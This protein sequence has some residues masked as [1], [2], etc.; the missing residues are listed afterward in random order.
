MDGAV[1][2]GKVQNVDIE[3]RQ[4]RVFF[5]DVNIMSGWLKV[6]Q[7]PPFIPAINVEQ[8]TEKEL[9]GSGDAAFAEHSHAV[10]IKPWLPKIGD[11]VL[12]LYTPG[13]NADGYVLGAI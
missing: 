10:I 8:R 7:S 12:C 5:G 6:I 3:K 2:I 4:V 11:N 1:R 13:F 9:G